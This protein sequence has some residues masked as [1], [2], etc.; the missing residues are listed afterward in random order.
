MKDALFPPWTAAFGFVLGA[1]IGSFLNMVIYR[2]PRLGKEIV[3]EPEEAGGEP[4]RFRL[5]LVEPKRSICPKCKHALDWPDLFPLFSWLSTGGKCRYCHEPVSSRYFW[6]ELLNALLFTGIWLRF[7]SGVANPDVLSAAVYALVTA[8]LV[9]I[10]FID[11]ELYIIPDELNAFLLV[12]ALIYAGLTGHIV[13]ALWGALVGWG[14]IWGLALLGRLA[15]GKDA[16]GDG[17]IKMMRG[18]GALIGPL[19][20]LADIG[21][22]VVLGLIGGVAGMWFASRAAQRKASDPEAEPAGEDAPHEPTP[23]WVVFFVGVWYLLCLDV[24]AMFVR[25]LDRWVSKLLPSEAVEEEDDW[26]P[27]ATTIPFGP[28]LAAGALACMLFGP[29]LESGLRAYWA[30]ATGRAETRA[31]NI[32]RRA[33]RIGTITVCSIAGGAFTG[34]GG[35]GTAEAPSLNVLRDGV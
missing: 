10:I 22:A 21:I 11:A 31:N 20:L 26:Q 3:E 29:A 12:V 30:N 17:D 16:M 18:V 27:S 13:N 24:L 9:A 34:F 5:S 6:V 7:M 35:R 32:D 23:V 33:T 2:L 15:F 28:Y 14:I 8:A 25:P 19:L 1:I 4:K